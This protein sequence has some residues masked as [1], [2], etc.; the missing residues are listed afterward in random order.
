M[1]RCWYETWLQPGS[2]GGRLLVDRG[3]LNNVP[4]DAMAD[5]AERTIVAV[6]V[7]RRL[8]PSDAEEQPL[9]AI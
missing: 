9:P 1:S 8:E 4:V 7:V 3:V 6:D 2:R 5:T